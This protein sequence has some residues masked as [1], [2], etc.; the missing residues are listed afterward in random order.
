MTLALASF[1]GVLAILLGAYWLF[2]L[3]LEGAADRA[4]KRRLKP[5]ESVRAPKAPLL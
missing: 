3:R 5:T 2:V 1:V 4:L